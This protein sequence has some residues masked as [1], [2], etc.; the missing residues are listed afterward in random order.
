[1]SERTND[2][3]PRKVHALV[4]HLVIT[5]HWYNEII[6]GRKLIEYRAMSDHWKKLIWKRRDKITHVRFQCGFKKNPLKMTFEVESIDVGKCPYDGWN[7][8]YYR[9]FFK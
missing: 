2:D 6:A 8:Q 4:L 9:V 3:G 1:M 5:E 7:D